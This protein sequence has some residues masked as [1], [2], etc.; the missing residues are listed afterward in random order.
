MLLAIKKNNN[1]KRTTLARYSTGA[2]WSC[3][4]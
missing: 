4:K 3:V 1:K 2:H